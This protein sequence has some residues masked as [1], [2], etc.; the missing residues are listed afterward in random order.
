MLL[1]MFYY[2]NYYKYGFIFIFMEE[3]ED[4]ADVNYEKVR[5]SVD[6][7]DV[8]PC[9]FLGAAL[10]AFS[11]YYTLGNHADW[12]IL[13]HLFCAGDHAEIGAVGVLVG[14]GLLRIVKKYL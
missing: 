12:S 13:S 11:L 4:I 10:G 3:L 14:S 9:V 7:S 6:S 2:N 5:S 8:V 1:D